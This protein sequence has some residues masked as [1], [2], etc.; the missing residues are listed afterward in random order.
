MEHF[1]VI[2]SGAAEKDFRQI[3]GYIGRE[4]P[5]N[6]SKVFERIKQKASELVSMP[7]RGRIVPELER[8]G[9][10]HYRELVFSPWRLIY[11][12]SGN[13]V[14]VFC[15]VDSRRNVEDVLLDRLAGE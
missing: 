6:A 12:I 1:D 14:L 13:E 5:V 15:L 9:I 8:Q 3:I 10:R 4:N 11:R 2:W 7:E